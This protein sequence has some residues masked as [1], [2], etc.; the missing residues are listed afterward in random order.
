MGL[1]PLSPATAQVVDFR[2]TVVVGPSGVPADDG[3]A[4]IEALAGITASAE[5]PV[6]LKIE[7]GRYDLGGVSLVMK[8]FVDV[9]GSGPAVT[10]LTGE[11]AGAFG[12]QQGVVTVAR[13]SELRELTVENR[14]DQTI[15]SDSAAIVV[16][17]GGRMRDVNAVATG[18]GVLARAILTTFFDSEEPAELSNVTARAQTRAVQVV[19]PGLEADGLTAKG[20]EGLFVSSG[21]VT[22]RNAIVEGTNFAALVANLSPEVNFVATQLVGELACGNSQCRCVNAYNGAFEPLANDCGS[23]LPT[24]TPAPPRD[25]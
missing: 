22:L 14:F 5:A 3:A 6:L 24:P 2:S 9:E 13:N 1:L 10:L 11:V 23:F 19:F 12:T 4:L 16:R 15:T 8:P 7:P 25:R 17:A 20:A 18:S 21:A